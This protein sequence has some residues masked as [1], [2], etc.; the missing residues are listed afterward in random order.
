VSESFLNEASLQELTDLLEKTPLPVIMR[1]FEQVDVADI[2][3]FLLL[4]DVAAKTISEESDEIRR[5]LARAADSKSK[6]Q[7]EGTLT[8]H[9]QQIFAQFPI[10]RQIRIAEQIA[11]TEIVE[12][13]QAEQ[14]WEELIGKMKGVLQSTLFFGNG[15]K[16]LAKFMGQVD[17][18][19]QNQLMEVLQK[20]QPELANT[21]ADCLFTFEDLL[22]VPDETIMTLLQVLETN[23]L[24]L[25]L[26]A[27]PAAIQDRFFENMSATQAEN[28]EA[29]SEQLTFEQKQLS[30]TA[31]QS[32]VGMVRNFAAKGLLKIR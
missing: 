12:T 32:V 1:A 2:A 17:I 20:S 23:T 28:V 24:A 16:N 10:E 25:A 8:G 7:T 18:E 19:Q 31:R 9:A 11:A 22:E 5:T 13:Q 3:V 26:H 30:E 6:E 21:V 4:L 29:E 14:V 27:A 15:A